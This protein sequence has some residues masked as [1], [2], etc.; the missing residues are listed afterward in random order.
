MSTDLAQTAPFPTHSNINHPLWRK[1][2]QAYEPL[3]TALR[4]I[5][6]S[7]DVEISGGMFSITAELT[8]GSHLWVSSVEGLP[9]DPT[10]VQGYQVRRAHQDNPTIDELV[11]D[12]T[13]DGEDS[14]YGNNVVPLIQ[15]VA[16]FVAE[17]GLAVRLIDLLSVQI[18]GVSAKHRP[19]S[20]LVQ[21]PFDDR[22][23]AVKE[24]GYAT[25]DLMQRGWRCIHEQGGT[26]WP[27]TVWEREGE[28]A[29]VFLAHVG[30][31]T[32]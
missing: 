9:F 30:Q 14:R 2:W 25:H 17:R 12:S 28:I 1:L 4:R 29:T 24:Y 16:A 31:V 23:V 3:I 7:T 6:L 21:G 15:A 5:P 11:Y 32:A 18:Q 27:L 8:D 13:E 26:V 22:H 19:L 10:D 20:E